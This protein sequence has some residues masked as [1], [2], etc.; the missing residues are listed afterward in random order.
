[1]SGPMFAGLFVNTE[2]VDDAAEVTLVGEFDLESVAPVTE[3]LTATLAPP[4]PRLVLIDLS[5]LTFISG[6]GVSTL[7]GALAEAIYRGADLRLYGPR[8]R[9]VRRAMAV[10]GADHLLRI[11][12]THADAVRDTARLTTWPGRR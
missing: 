12:P 3:A 6:T 9:I 5:N 2:R 7:L 8:H 11:Y 4:P 1:M 10:T